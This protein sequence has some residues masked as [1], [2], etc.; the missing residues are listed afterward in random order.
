MNRRQFKTNQLHRKVN[1]GGGTQQLPPIRRVSSVVRQYLEKRLRT[2][3]KSP[4]TA[5][6]LI[7]A[8]ARAHL[9]PSGETLTG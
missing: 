5:R 6:G 2:S 1:V 7:V 9:L 3:W 8:S 4:S